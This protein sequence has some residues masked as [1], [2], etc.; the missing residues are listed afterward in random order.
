MIDRGCEDAAGRDARRLKIGGLVCLAIGSLAMGLAGARLTTIDWM[1]LAGARRILSIAAI[2]FT[3]ANVF[4]LG[5]ILLLAGLRGIPLLTSGRAR[6]GA[7][8]KMAGANLLILCFAYV[9][10]WDE[11]TLGRT[12]SDSWAE[13]P[14]LILFLL[15]ARNGVVLVRTGWKYEAVSADRL[16]AEDPRPPVI[17]L[18]SFHDDDQILIPPNRFMRLLG[19]ALAY[20]PPFYLAAISPEQEL[21]LFMSRV[22][23][24]VAIGRPGERL[25]EL[26][27]A[28]LYAADDQWR[29]R[30]SNLVRQA[31]VV[32]IR[33]GNTP[34]LWWEIE[35]TMIAVPASR[36]ILVCLGAAEQ[37]KTFDQKFTEKFGAPR[38]NPET[39]TH[40]RSRWV[41]LGLAW[42]QSSLNRAIGRMVYFD[43]DRQPRS[44]R[45]QLGISWT[46]ILTGMGRPYKNPLE[47]ALTR[48]L[49]VIGLQP[50]ITRKSQTTAVL[51]A[52]F[53]GFVGL[54][55][56]YLDDRRKGIRYLVLAPIGISAILGL[57]DA[58]RLALL[59][60]PGFERRHPSQGQSRAA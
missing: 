33:A 46:A 52:L 24:V 55:H 5:L 49:H 19:P 7:W 28:R 31:R 50:A 23:P 30:V 13:A 9:G 12:L 2:W 32:L 6:R 53:G 21:A 40:S 43:K 36:V 54:H 58:V 22:G 16:L 45:I 11:T 25:P 44:E 38:V 27:A 57:V 60:A 20:L 4:A 51:L 17:Y 42:T 3:G 35:Q 8:T 15:A 37:L 10:I 41:S 48:V 34:N 29:D 1:A 26:G 14:V 18:R 59:D 39:E 56:F 47:S